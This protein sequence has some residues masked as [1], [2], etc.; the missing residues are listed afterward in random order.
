MN[1]M[2]KVYAG[3]GALKLEQI[4]PKLSRFEEKPVKSKTLEAKE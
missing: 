2:P 1:W 3:R 4:L